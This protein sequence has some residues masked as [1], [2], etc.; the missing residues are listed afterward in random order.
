MRLLNKP[1]PHPGTARHTTFMDGRRPPMSSTRTLLVA[2]SPVVVGVFVWTAN[3]TA[4]A[5]GRAPRPGEPLRGITAEERQLFLAGK[6]E[7]KA[8]EDAADGLGPT[9]NGT[10]CASCH[11]VPAV[12]GSSPQN[13]TRAQLFD[14]T[15]H[16]DLPGGSLFQSQAISP[17]CA[18]T[19]P[20]NANVI[21]PR[22]S[23]PLFG[24]GLIEAIPDRSIERYASLQARRHPEQAG[25]IHRIVD[26]ANG[27]SRIGRFGW[28]AQHAT[29]LTFSADAYLN[30]M[31][32]TSHVFPLENAP[33][34]DQARL[35]ACDTI[36]D[37]EDEDRDFELFAHFM[38]LLA[39]P[40]GKDE[41]SV[42][43]SRG[44]RGNRGRF[45]FDRVG[46]AVCHYDRYRAQGPIR[47]IRGS[48]VKAFSDF[49]LHDVGT[50]DGIVQGGAAANEL[51]TP[52][53]WGLRESAPYLHDGSA[54]TIEEAIR[55]HANQGAAASEAFDRLSPG[56]QEA[57]ID[58]LSSL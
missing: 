29:L 12:G 27:M 21:A 26:A 51:R 39:P 28:K 5:R 46:C 53:L 36:P 37:P 50:G 16:F 14:G 8:V 41:R 57:L 30:E 22:Q 54:P 18:E 19:V 13:E 20:P 3:D 45:L 25:R 23:T 2:L 33:N 48:A 7:F 44:R 52:P 17:D 58:F 11:G 10:S 15:D 34:G 9:F 4:A 56:E 35:A 1:I 6:E 32:I 55:R 43:R 24:S 31:G 40:P 38:R 47:A 42:R 49:L